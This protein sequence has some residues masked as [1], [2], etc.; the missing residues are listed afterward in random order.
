MIL[1]VKIC[2]NSGY[3]V[4]AYE[5]IIY[6]ADHGAHIINCSW[7]G[8]GS[9]NQYHQDVVNYATNNKGALVVAAA[10]NSNNSN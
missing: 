1:P 3:L 8:K 10:G 9:F 6:A 2:N 4:G 7:G 5:G